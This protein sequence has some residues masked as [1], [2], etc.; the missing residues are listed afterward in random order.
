MADP[1]P[2]ER[3]VWQTMIDDDLDTLPPQTLIETIRYLAR[4]LLEVTDG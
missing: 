1:T 4:R 2:A 3:E